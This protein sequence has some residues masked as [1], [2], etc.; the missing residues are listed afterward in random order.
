MGCKARHDVPCSGIVVHGGGTLR[1]W[2]DEMVQEC[3]VG[4][5]AGGR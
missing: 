5:H 1:G 4:F 3:A 2:S